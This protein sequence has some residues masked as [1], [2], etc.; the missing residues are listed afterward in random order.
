MERT[1]DYDVTLVGTGGYE[2]DSLGQQKIVETQTSIC[3]CRVPVPRQ[4]FYKAG[5]NGI[6]IKEILIIHPYEYSGE[7]EVVFE[8]NRLQILKTYQI[9]AEELEL[10][11]I[12]KVGGKN[13]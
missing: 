13:G 4:E 11:C 5:Q 8:G 2:E 1:W 6:E 9:S 10:T 3:C 7:P 12:K